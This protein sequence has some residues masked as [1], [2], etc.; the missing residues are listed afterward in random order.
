MCRHVDLGNGNFAI[1]CGGK[2]KPKFCACG[3]EGVL[4]CDWKVKSNKGSG[5]C[6]EPVC[7]RHAMQVGPDKHLCP[8]HQR[9]WAEWQRKHPGLIAQPDYAQMS[10]L[11]GKES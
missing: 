3:R 5:T 6:D 1:V 4:L 2:H 9:E 8:A 10:L 11:E 7:K